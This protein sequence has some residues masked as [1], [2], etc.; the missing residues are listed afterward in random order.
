MSLGD[1]QVILDYL[2]EP[3]EDYVKDPSRKLTAATRQ[4][5]NTNFEVQVTWAELD[6]SF[7]SRLLDFLD[8]GAVFPF[9]VKVKICLQSN[10]DKF[11]TQSPVCNG[12]V[13]RHHQTIEHS[14]DV[15]ENG[16]HDESIKIKE[17][18]V[19]LPQLRFDEN[20]KVIEGLSV[21]NKRKRES[22][23]AELRHEPH[24]IDD[25]IEMFIGSISS[26]PFVSNGGGTMKQIK[27]DV[28]DTF[29]VKH[30]KTVKHLTNRLTI[31]PRTSSDRKNGSFNPRIR[32]LKMPDD[33]NSSKK[34]KKT[35]KINKDKLKSSAAKRP[36]L[37]P[38]SIANE[39]E[40]FE[41]PTQPK[42]KAKKDITT[43]S[44]K[45]SKKKSSPPPVVKVEEAD[46][47][48]VKET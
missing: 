46:I 17:C 3:I 33:V 20:G 6:A 4:I 14:V 7:Y 16:E 12:S 45:T 2:S 32:L 9:V 1:W 40:L 37:K 25:P 5:N 15:V 28:R 36:K 13:V 44:E 38:Q 8:F 19:R 39:S 27:K 21:S 30:K 47:I 11:P 35:K 41:V 26:T 23:I 48:E 24:R 34:T 43:A 29:G 31:T 18:F 22:S 10:I 42:K